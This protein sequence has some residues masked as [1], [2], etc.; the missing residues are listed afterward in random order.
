MAERSLFP[1]STNSPSFKNARHAF[2]VALFPFNHKRLVSLDIPVRLRVLDSRLLFRSPQSRMS[3][4]VQFP[5][6]YQLCHSSFA[7]V[8]ENSVNQVNAADVIHPGSQ[9]VETGP[10]ARRV[11]ENGNASL[12]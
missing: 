11:D 9:K 7:C 4:R 3:P 10:D 1:D 6:R 12:N 2:V 8:I 5:N